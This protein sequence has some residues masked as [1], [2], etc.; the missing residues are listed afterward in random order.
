MIRARFTPALA[1][2]VALSLPAAAAPLGAAGQCAAFWG[3][4]AGLA[5]EVAQLP[6]DGT[7][8]RL[9]AA[10]AAAEPGSA[11]ALSAATAEMGRMLRAAMRG[12]A[13]AAAG[14]EQTALVCEGMARARGLI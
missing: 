11:A 4:M 3:A 12:D 7:D 13:N 10:F 14:V 9:A 2:L 5:A 6:D 1:A 8:A